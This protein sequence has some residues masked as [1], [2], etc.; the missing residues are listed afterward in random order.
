MDR[1]TEAANRARVNMGFGEA[2][3]QKLSVPRNN[4]WEAV[5]DIC[6]EFAEGEPHMDWFIEEAEVHLDTITDER[7]NG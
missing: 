3:P 4:L 5:S 2:D 7:I 6:G 1:F